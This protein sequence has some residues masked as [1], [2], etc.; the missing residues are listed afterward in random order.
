VMAQI[1]ARSRGLGARD[2][3]NRLTGGEEAVQSAF[4]GRGGCARGRGALEL[5]REGGGRENGGGAPRPVPHGRREMG[6]RERERERE[7]EG[8]RRVSRQRE[9]KKCGRQRPPVV[10]C[11]RRRCR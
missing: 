6:E 2:R 10:R 5:K 7:R 9:V 4:V 8:P 1:P 11:S 3:P